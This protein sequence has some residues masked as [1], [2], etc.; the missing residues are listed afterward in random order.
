MIA[1]VWDETNGMLFF[2]DPHQSLADLVRFT[3]TQSLGFWRPLPTLLVAAILHFIPNAWRLLRMVDALLLLGAVA[4]L[5]HVIGEWRSPVIPSRGDGE[6]SQV[7]PTEIPRYA[8][9]DGRF[10]VTVAILFSGS[11]I[12]TAGW[13]A[14]IFDA[15]ALLL[16]AVALLLMT[17]QRFVAA[18]VI[19]GVAFFC[20]ETTALALV[21]LLPLVA[22]GR[23]RFRDAVR[24]GIPAAILGLA[25][26]WLRSRIVPFGSTAD[27]HG[28]SLHELGPTVIGVLESFWRQT[29]KPAHPTILGFLWLPFAIAMLRRPRLIGAALVFI[30]ATI[31]IYWGM[32]GEYQR[33]ILIHHLDFV[34][35]LYL[36]P[37]ALM[38]VL[39]AIEKR[40]V[41]VAV[42]LIPI[43]WGAA[44]TYRDHE[45]FQRTYR[46]IYR[47]APMTVD[48]AEKPLH[49]TVRHVE[50]G[51]FPN[52]H[53]AIDAR[54]GKLLYR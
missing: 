17:R 34:G 49:D 51:A 48:F 38:I 46:R 21:F 44:T 10:L 33:G 32:F 23:I 15:S 41:A 47:H 28:F 36:I 50:I 4:L 22:A 25:Y 31:V 29:L 40:T 2:S 26:F 5:I 39:L 24:V 13:Y 35:R 3:L 6:G 45:R 16:I 11:A 12:I 8:R 42:L 14:N 30:S 19:L 27:V 37:C 43:L 53:V 52:A 7:T 1:D 20:K 54:T 9:D 18:G